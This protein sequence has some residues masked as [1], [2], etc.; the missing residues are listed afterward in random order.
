MNLNLRAVLYIVVF[1]I[2]LTGSF[3]VS[4]IYLNAPGNLKLPQLSPFFGGGESEGE[5]EGTSGEEEATEPIDLDPQV[6][7]ELD[8][9]ELQNLDL[10]L[11]P[12]VSPPGFV[13]P[14]YPEFPFSPRDNELYPYVQC[15]TDLER[16]LQISDE[17]I[18][19]E[20]REFWE[21]L[22][23]FDLQGNNGEIYWEPGFGGGGFTCKIGWRGRF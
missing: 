3:Y 4:S 23:C 10:C 22:T 19:G 17:D 1:M 8:L 7:F 20:A 18:F 6:C 16:Y 15:C 12:D 14:I 9:S 13:F 21:S 11:W 2:L 5:V